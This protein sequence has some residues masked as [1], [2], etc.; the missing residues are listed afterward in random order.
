[1]PVVLLGLGSNLGD[2]RAIL[3]DAVSKIERRLEVLS[4]SEWFTYPAVGGP[5][6]QQDFLNGALVGRTE[7]APHDLV[8]QLQRIEREAGRERIRRWDSRTLDCDLL[9]YGD[10]TVDTET[11]QVPHPRMITRRFVLEPAASVA[12]DMHHPQTGWTMKR[13]LHHLE[14]ATPYYCVLGPDDDRSRQIAQKI[15]ESTGFPL[16]TRAQ[17]AGENSKSPVAWIS[18]TSEILNDF[19][20]SSGLI[21]T[22]WNWE[23]WL[24]D[25]RLAIPIEF[26]S[27]LAPKLIIV[28]EPTG[29]A[30]AQKFAKLQPSLR[31][32]TLFLSAKQEDAL[33]DAIGCVQAM[34]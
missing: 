4:I 20:V 8:Q 15:S 12:P 3:E 11:L 30:F 9:L 13:L 14:N 31:R 29:S 24:E 1:M 21:S 28:T 23:P 19:D 10:Q 26:R 32:P 5:T 27:A 17:V 34:Q 18:V 22:F 2:R 6:G 33:Q 16:V 25:D 7:L